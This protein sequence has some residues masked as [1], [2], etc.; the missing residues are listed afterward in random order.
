[1]TNLVFMCLLRCR[2]LIDGNIRQ[3]SQKLAIVLAAV[4]I[5]S[6]STPQ[7]SE[8][9]IE[10][11]SPTAPIAEISIIPQPASVTPLDGYFVFNQSTKIIVTD[12]SG[13]RS[14]AVLNGI[15]QSEFG[16]SLR[17][18]QDIETRGSIVFSRS[19]PNDT[20][21]ASESYILKIDPAFIQIKG[22]ERGI[23]YGI[24]SL[25]QLIPSDFGGEIRIAAAEISD[26]PRFRYRGMHLDVSRHFMPAEFVKKYIDLISRY[27]INYFHWH[28]T[29]DQGWRIEIKHYPLLTEIGSRRPETV[30]GRSDKPYIGDRIPVEGFY[31]QEEIRDVVDY[32]RARFVTIVPE[33]DLPG[34]SS[35]AL[36]AYPQF[37]C[38]NNY[39]PKVKTTW[40][41]FPDIY[42]PQPPTLK[43]IE[44]VLSEVTDLFPDS[45]YIHV[46]G[47]EV[48]KDYWKDSAAVKELKRREGLRSDE[49]VQ[50]WMFRRIES[51]VSSRGRK[52]IGWDGIMEGGLPPSAVVMSWNGTA[53]GISAARAKHDVIMAPLDVTYFDHPQGDPN[54]EPLSIYHK[55]IT[56]KTVYDFDP[57]PSELSREDRNYIIGAEGC[58]WTEFIRN[59]KEVEYMVFPRALALA[60]VLWS[61]AGNKNFTR[62]TSRLSGELARL[63]RRQVNYRIPPPAG[64]HDQNLLLTENTV[65]NLT[66][67]IKNGKIYY[68]LDGSP[69]NGRSAVYSEPFTLQIPPRQAVEV[70][71]KVVASDG[72]ESAVYAAKYERRPPAFA[73]KSR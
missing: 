42:C 58:V 53:P 72:R 41:A 26:A 24:Q 60:E 19:D 70:R 34:H 71:T 66:V 23:F 48:Q 50:S 36:A 65:V 20:S 28:L 5:T 68:T 22:S 10:S 25:S 33:I 16:F 35:A 39:K 67:P 61:D 46:G 27:K 63:D 8:V 69:P 38:K 52:I 4:F 73:L 56:L 11:T 3:R 37:G 43:F 31:S 62:F 29:D 13:E 47:D 18:T 17:T 9:S 7:K 15:L 45:P 2:K 6:C 49:A 59:P 55:S 51:F 1:M 12:E 14:A 30:V 32:A 44:D 57:V 21:D 40:G 64:L 54:L